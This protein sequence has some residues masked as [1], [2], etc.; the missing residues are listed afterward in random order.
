MDGID[1]N[2]QS[3][4]ERQSPN[5]RHRLLPLLQ[6]PFV[7]LAGCFRAVCIVS[8]VSIRINRFADINSYML[9]YIYPEMEIPVGV[10][11]RRFVRSFSFVEEYVNRRSSHL[12]AG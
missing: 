4:R 12:S 2:R 7:I 11:L 3:V 10:L 6:F 5:R 1:I 9:I 8:V